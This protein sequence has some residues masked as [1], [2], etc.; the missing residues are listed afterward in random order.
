MPAPAFQTMTEQLRQRGQRILGLVEELLAQ[1]LLSNMNDRG[2]GV[3]FA[4]GY[5][6]GNLDEEARRIQSRLLN[7]L[8]RY[9]PLIDVMVRVAPEGLRRDV[10]SATETLTDIADQ[11]H[12][13]V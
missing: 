8:E 3:F 5:A 11:T 4:P 7:E 13:S 1:S 9:T 6:W 12:L 2:G 10:E